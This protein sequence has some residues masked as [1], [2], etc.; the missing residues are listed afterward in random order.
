MSDKEACDTLSAPKHGPEAWAA[1]EV[2][3]RAAEGV[4]E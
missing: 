4:F 3:V 2:T 1:D